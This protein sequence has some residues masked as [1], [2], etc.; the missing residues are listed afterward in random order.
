[1]WEWC[2]PIL[3]SW[4]LL[5]VFNRC[6]WFRERHC[7]ALTWSVM[8]LDAHDFWFQ[9][10]DKHSIIA[11]SQSRSLT[12]LLNVVLARCGATI[13]RLQ[14][15]DGLWGLTSSIQS[16]VWV[17]RCECSKHG[18]TTWTVFLEDKRVGEWWWD[19]TGSCLLGKATFRN[20]SYADIR[21][22]E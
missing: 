16:L 10:L 14:C 12:C 4:L 11:S 21:W 20:S 9:S 7:L 5:S 13:V 15:I 19:E 2:A 18:N 22:C 8:L 17:G 6:A 1:M 3:F